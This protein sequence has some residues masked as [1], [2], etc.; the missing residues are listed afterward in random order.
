MKHYN[1]L[2]DFISD[3]KT[4]F[5]KHIATK[6]MLQNNDCILTFTE[7][8]TKQRHITF[9]YIDGYLHIQG[10]F[11]CASFTW[12]NPRNTIEQLASFANGIGYFLSKMES[13]GR[14]VTPSS[15][16]KEWDSDICISQVLEYFK[17]H[18]IEIED[19]EEYYDWKQYTESFSDW[20]VFLNEN[21]A[22]FFQDDDYYEYAYDFGVT[23]NIKCF[24]WAYGLIKAVKFLEKELK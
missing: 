14:S 2:D 1:S 8:N 23:T 24:I 7:P 15:L 11:G 5:D 13:G 17:E 9:V 3:Y 10:D 18:E 16:M 19:W 6:T 21:G 20:T 12:H 22:N 4:M